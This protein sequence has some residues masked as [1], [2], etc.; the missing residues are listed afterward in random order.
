MGLSEGKAI[1]WW[2]IVGVSSFPEI[3]LNPNSNKPWLYAWRSQVSVLFRLHMDLLLKTLDSS[4]RCIWLPRKSLMP[5]KWA[6][7]LLLHCYVDKEICNA[8]RVKTMQDFVNPKGR[9]CTGTRNK[10]LQQC[11]VRPPAKRY[12]KTVGIRG[13]QRA[14]KLSNCKLMDVR[15]IYVGLLL[16]C[17]GDFLVA[18]IPKFE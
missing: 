8:L 7:P 4:H 13:L 10:I 17:D 11:V 18:D 14:P 2:D 9:S 16:T 12:W 5:R 3:L 15:M 6:S 1:Q